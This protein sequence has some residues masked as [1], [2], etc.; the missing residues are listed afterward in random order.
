MTRR[1][2][3]VFTAHAQK[4]GAGFT[5]QRPFPSRDLA[6]EQTDPFLMIDEIGPTDANVNS[7]GA[8]LH[9]HRGFDTD[10]LEVRLRRAP[11]Q[12]G[13]QGLHGAS[14]FRHKKSC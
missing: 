4:E 7:P 2:V 11:R 1:V 8:P 5:V 12:P 14:S 6:D 9:P 13:Q 3:K 10:L